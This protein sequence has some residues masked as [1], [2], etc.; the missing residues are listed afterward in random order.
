M[1]RPGPAAPLRL[2][3]SAT[4]AVDELLAALESWSA[5]GRD[6][7]PVAFL[8]AG[9]GELLGGFPLTA[10]K[11]TELTR[12]LRRAASADSGTAEPTHHPEGDLS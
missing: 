9:D 3:P 11:V 4:E 12:L 6:G 5:R 7:E 2:V 1:S 10:A 8:E